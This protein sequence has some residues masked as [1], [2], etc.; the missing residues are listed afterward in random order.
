MNNL[1]MDDSF[2]H[3]DKLLVGIGGAGAGLVTALSNSM[4]H[5]SGIRGLIIDR[6]DAL[7]VPND[8]CEL[9]PIAALKQGQPRGDSLAAARDFQISLSSMDRYQNASFVLLVSGLGGGVGSGV[10]AL[11]GQYFQSR[12]IPVI[13]VVIMPDQ[14]RD[15]RKRCL[16]AEIALSEI[17]NSVDGVIPISSAESTLDS[18]SEPDILTKIQVLC[19]ILFDSGIVS[20]D[21]SRLRNLL[22]SG[23]QA[24]IAVTEVSGPDKGKCAAEKILHHPVI[25]DMINQPASLILH[26]LAGM[27]LSL[28]DLDEAASHIA[29][30]WQNEV[31]ITY[32][33]SMNPEYNGKL[34]LGIVAGKLMPGKASGIDEKSGTGDVVTSGTQV[35]FPKT[36]SSPKPNQRNLEDAGPAPRISASLF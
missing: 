10:T 25:K 21:L 9:M 6:V 30:H 24:S 35:V 5:G 19:D 18:G 28:Y 16:T 2:F 22:T 33:A 8:I 12:K 23:A 26:L 15:G 20:I 11:A 4:D 32:G 7:A 1:R 17:K 34:R 13:A 14:Q 3:G 29:D 27:D 36:P 31:E